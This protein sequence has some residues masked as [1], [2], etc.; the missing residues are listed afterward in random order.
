MEENE[1]KNIIPC[2]DD[3]DG[4]HVFIGN[5]FVNETK[6]LS[7]RPSYL[8]AFVLSYSRVLLNDIINTIYGKDR[9]TVDGIK[10]QVYT[11]DTDSLVVHCSQIQSLI[12]ANMIGDENGKLTDDLNKKFNT[13]NNTFQFS[14]ITEFVT[15]APKKYALKYVM[16]NNERKEKITCNGISKKNMKF[17]NPFNSAEQLENL[18]FD[19]FKKMYVDS[20]DTFDVMGFNLYNNNTYFTLPDKMKRISFK[21][22]H[23]DTIKKI[24]LFSIH[25]A[26]ITRALF[27]Q[28]W[29]GRDSC[30]YPYTI[31]HF[32]AHINILKA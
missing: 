22:T 23:G 5:K 20:Q 29:K 16:P 6:H 3:D 27:H 2:E 19:I 26:Q 1:L 12:N 15:S 30:I 9:Y 13:G 17:T 32:S 28:Q 4:F 11:G 10:K 14:K 24:P 18:N 8:G 31:P 25:S 7:G 21:R